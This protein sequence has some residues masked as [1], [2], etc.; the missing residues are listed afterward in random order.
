VA[1]ID[2]SQQ[3]YGIAAAL[4]DDTAMLE[5]Y[6]SGDPYLKF[7]KQAKAVPDDA[8]KESHKEVRHLF[9]ECQLAV[10]YGMRE[11]KLALKINRSEAEA[12]E[13]L[14]SHHQVYKKFWRWSDGAEAY[15]MAM[16][17]L[18][19]IFGWQLF[20]ES[21]E[22]PN[23]RRLRNFPVQGNAAE[24]FRLA[25]SLAIERGISVIG[26]VHDAVLIE[27]PADQ[28]DQAIAVT[29]EAMAEASRVV[30]GGF[31]LRSEVKRFSYPQRFEDEKGQDMWQRV[32]RILA[33][34]VD[35]QGDQ[36]AA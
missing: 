29:Q 7:A 13:L 10:N 19:T 9:K 34:L 36:L 18:H 11:K 32:S 21:G 12:K 25:C 20:L 4:A 23:P 2:Y 3:E 28:L 27:S 31:T 24:M 6:L 1:Y 5:A 14:R 15:A 16:G 8:T 17:K 22:I 33:G 30:L 35:R 26:P